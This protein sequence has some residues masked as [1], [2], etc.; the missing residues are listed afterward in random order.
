M[1]DANLLLVADGSRW[2]V[3]RIREGYRPHPRHWLALAK[4]AGFVNPLQR[5][6]S[7]LLSRVDKDLKR[8]MNFG[9]RPPETL[10]TLN[11]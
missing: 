11:L 8:L 3:G 2:Y 6:C 5:N 9:R 7:Q 1:K 10:F 4:L